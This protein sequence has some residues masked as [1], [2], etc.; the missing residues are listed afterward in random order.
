MPI[1][2]AWNESHENHRAPHHVE[3]PERL[4]AVLQRLEGASIR[5]H[6]LPVDYDRAPL[7]LVHLVHTEEHVRFVVGAG[8]RGFDRLDP[9]T[10]IT[11][12]SVR[13]ALDAVGALLAVTKAVLDGKT[14]SGFAAVRPPGHH[15]TPDHSMGFCLFSNVAIAARWAQRVAGLGRVL[16]VDFDVHHGNGTQDVFYD[17]PSVMYMSVHQAPF[18]PG[19]GA[20]HERGTGQAEGSTINI[21]LPRGTGDAGYGRVFR[22]ILRPV[23]RR[24][25][26]EIIFLS[27]GYDAHWKDLLGG[28]HVSTRG[29]ADIM[30]ELR[31]WANESCDGRI[32][33]TLE[34]GYHLDALAHSVH[35]TLD[36]LHD[37]EADVDDPIGVAPDE[38]TD[39]KNYLVDVASSLL[40]EAQ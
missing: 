8:E 36:V 15:A 24:F 19:T 29:F 6:L 40:D 10:Y 21:P 30:R 27:S 23:A 39:I 5:P 9:D 32:V 37:I 22:E 11:K 38:D 17:D 25:R 26:P 12:S 13:A 18:Y 16:I 2:F 1:A 20:A 34:G 28:M 33:S 3:R 14:A 31:G 35:A 7:E 4:R